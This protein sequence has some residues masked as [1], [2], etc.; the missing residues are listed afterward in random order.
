MTKVPENHDVITT[1]W[2]ESSKRLGYSGERVVASLLNQKDEAEAEAPRCPKCKAKF[3]KQNP[4]TSGAGLCREC[5][6]GG[7]F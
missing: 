7:A 4:E 3:T 6:T 1:A 2:Q 5:H